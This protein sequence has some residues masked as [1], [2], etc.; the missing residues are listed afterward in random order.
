[1][2]AITF[3]STVFLVIH[4]SED[5]GGVVWIQDIYATP[6][7]P[8]IIKTGQ[9]IVEDFATIEERDARAEALGYVFQDIVE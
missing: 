9:P 3:Q 4:S 6:E 7:Q 8:V 5:I 1:M 2:T